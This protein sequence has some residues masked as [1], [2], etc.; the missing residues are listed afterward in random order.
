MGRCVGQRLS[1]ARVIAVNTGRRR[2]I[3]GGGSANHVKK[4]AV[5]E[6]IA[7]LLREKKKVK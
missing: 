7:S 1:S 2:E 6:I 4:V 3:G 5:L